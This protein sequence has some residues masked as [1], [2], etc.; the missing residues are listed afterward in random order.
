MSKDGMVVEAVGE[1]VMWWC[2]VAVAEKTNHTL[3]HSFHQINFYRMMVVWW[4]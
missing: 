2:N 1:G 4:G 3:L